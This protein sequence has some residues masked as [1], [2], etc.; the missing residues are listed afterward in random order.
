MAIFNIHWYE[1]SSV[2]IDDYGK[3]VVFEHYY[4]NK[5]CRH[6]HTHKS[7][8]IERKKESYRE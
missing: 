6:T 7:E 4:Y 2:Y 5:I 1:R 8:Y 3:K